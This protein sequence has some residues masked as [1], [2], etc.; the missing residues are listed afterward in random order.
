[1]LK[2]ESDHGNS[3]KEI[4]KQS[5]RAMRKQIIDKKESYLEILFCIIIDKPNNILDEI[6]LHK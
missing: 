6:M 2:R 4:L 3:N 1:M 5:E